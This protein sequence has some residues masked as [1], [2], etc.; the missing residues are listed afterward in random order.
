MKISVERK[1]R[2]SGVAAV[3][4]ALLLVVLVSAPAWCSRGWLSLLI[5][6]FYFIALAQMWNLLA[7][8]AGVISLGQQ[9][10]LGLGGYAF[11]F[12]ASI[13]GWHP[14][15]ALLAA[16]LV[17]ALVA[18]PSAMV[19]LR[20]HGAYLAIGTWVFA[21]VFRLVFAEIT[22]LGAGSGISLPV[23]VARS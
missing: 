8:F 1:T 15:L 6:V 23:Q 21:E 20:M 17:G 12:L 4:S 5:E 7:G 19:I 2:F 3:A 13:W 14:L 9:A 11:F 18:L 16:G 10:F 22:A